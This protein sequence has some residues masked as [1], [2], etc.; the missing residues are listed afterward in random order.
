MRNRFGM[1]GVA[2]AAGVFLALGVALARAGG[3]YEVSQW[4][5]SGG[6]QVAV[7]NYVLDDTSGQPA[8]GELSAGTY[9]IGGGFWGGGTA[10]SASRLSYLSLVR[11]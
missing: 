11:H 7:G 1:K 4:S 3:G 2:I 5:I 9:T 10:K 6:G 8:A